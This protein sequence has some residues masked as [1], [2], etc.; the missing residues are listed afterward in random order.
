MSRGSPAFVRIHGEVMQVVARIPKGR[1]ATFADIGAFLDVV[2]RQVAFLLARRNDPAREAVPW[3]RVVSDDGALGR[4]KFDAHGRSQ[5][6]LLAADGVVL[7]P[8][9]RVPLTGRRRF[10]PTTRTTG[11]TPT[12]RSG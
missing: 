9:G 1:V 10:V 5:A 11:V 4:P 8:D 6:E 7:G 3:H 2:P 12:P